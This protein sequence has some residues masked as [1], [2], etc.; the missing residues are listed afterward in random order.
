MLLAGF[1]VYGNGAWQ[2]ALFPGQEAAAFTP[3]TLP[4][5]IAVVGSLLC[6]ARAIATLR[7]SE[8]A[9]D[10]GGRLGWVRV[11]GFCT[12]MVAY[13]VLLVQAGFIVATILF[14]G[15][16]FALLGERR[17]LILVILPTIFT[18]AFWFVMT[19]MLGLYLAPGALWLPEA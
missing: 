11:A 2:I 19:R 12:F 9:E 15:T 17:L 3:R 14:L 6:L 1:I 16:G 8:P 4:L 10:A 7:H 13:S 5:A 18:V